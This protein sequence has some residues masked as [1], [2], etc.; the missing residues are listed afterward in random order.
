MVKHELRVESLKAG[1]EIQQW[2][3]RSTSYEFK[4]TSYEFKSTG[5]EFKSTSLRIIKSMKTQVNSLLKQ[6]SKTR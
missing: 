4:S 3:F 6:P 2:E 1:V 5:Y